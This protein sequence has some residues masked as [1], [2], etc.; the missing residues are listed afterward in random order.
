MWGNEAMSRISVLLVHFS[1]Y[2]VVSDEGEIMPFLPLPVLTVSCILSV[3]ASCNPAQ[4]P[5][6]G[7]SRG[8]KSLFT[9]GDNTP[10][11]WLTHWEQGSALPPFPPVD[12]S[13]ASIII[14]DRCRHLMGDGRLIL[15]WQ[16]EQGDAVGTWFESEQS[17][18]RNR[19][20]PTILQAYTVYAAQ[21]HTTNSEEAT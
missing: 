14:D 20:A 18:Q 8:A 11:N 15:L 3:S 21:I 10:S 2:D 13:S 17:K 5:A 16:V 4:S 19:P 12:C 6:G 1:S 7:W 9:W